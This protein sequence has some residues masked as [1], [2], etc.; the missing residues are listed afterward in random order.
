MIV[1]CYNG[2]TTSRGSHFVRQLL[3]S[4]LLNPTNAITSR[5]LGGEMFRFGAGPAA[6]IEN[7]KCSY[8]G[9]YLEFWSNSDY[10]NIRD[11]VSYPKMH[12]NRWF[13]TQ[14]ENLELVGGWAGEIVRSLLSNCLT[15]ILRTPWGGL[16]R[17]LSPFRVC[18]WYHHRLCVL[19]L[20]E[21]ES[22]LKYHP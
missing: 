17:E 5:L 13:W 8:L 20:F 11:D 22:W 10:K 4:Q 21:R 3:V 19:D 2:C 18:P 12:S 9:Q 6:K 7:Q 15:Y 14:W 16:Y 1:P